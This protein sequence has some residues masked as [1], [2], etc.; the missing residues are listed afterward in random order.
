MIGII[1]AGNMGKAIALRIGQKVLITDIDKTKLRFSSNNRIVA[2]KDNISLVNRSEVIILAV[3]PQKMKAVL[4][5]IAPYAKTKLII[6][7]AAGIETSF[8]ERVLKY[9]KVVRV[10]PNMALLVGRG[11]SCIS[12]GKRTTSKDLRIVI[13]I[14]SRFGEVVGVKESLMSSVTA[15]SGSGPAYYFLF[16]DLLKK[17]AESCGLNKRLAAQLARAT[18]I[19]AACSCA[20]TKI[21]MEDFV[22][23]VASKGG[24]T[25]AALKVF[26]KRN[27]EAIVKQ[28]VKA[29]KDR[30]KELKEEVWQRSA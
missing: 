2:L 30:S 25:E 27:L 12:A 19:G 10:M 9:A 15:V 24:T 3:K 17:A 28:A 13:K 4:K 14:F 18:F 6:S 7:I 22:N 1:G 26:K 5:D 8:I 20:G 29:A 16:T 11:I 21:S 23:K